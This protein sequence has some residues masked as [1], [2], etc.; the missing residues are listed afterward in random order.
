MRAMWYMD[1]CGVRMQ[2]LGP[3]MALVSGKAKG[4]S[5]MKFGCGAGGSFGACGTCGGCASCVGSSMHSVDFISF[6]P[7][8][9]ARPVSN[10]SSKTI[11]S[12]GL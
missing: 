12:S 9:S 5:P 3:Q 2:P 7:L 11:A 6:S 8:T 10:A 1:N 4:G